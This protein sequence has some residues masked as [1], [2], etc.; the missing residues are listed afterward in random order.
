MKRK[1]NKMFEERYNKVMNEVARSVR[2][3]LERLDEDE[4]E[5]CFGDDC[6]EEC[7]D[8][9]EDEDSLN[10]MGRRPVRSTI[11]PKYKANVR[12]ALGRRNYDEQWAASVKPLAKFGQDELLQRY[13]VGLLLLG[14]EC[15]QT[16]E[17]IDD[18]AVFGE[19]ARK[20]LAQG[21][22]LQEIIDLYNEQDKITIQKRQGSNRP[23]KAYRKPSD[24]PSTTFDFDNTEDGEEMIDEVEPV[25][26][27]EEEQE[28][29][30]NVD[31][32]PEITDEPEE[33]FPAY[34]DVDVED[35][36]EVDLNMEDDEEDEM[37]DIMDDEEVEDE[38]DEHNSY[39]VI[40]NLDELSEEDYRD[41]NY[42]EAFTEFG[43]NGDE[44]IVE[45]GK[46]GTEVK[47]VADKDS[48]V[49]TIW[50]NSAGELFNMIYAIIYASFD[51]DNIFIETKLRPAVEA[52][53]KMYMVKISDAT[54]DANE[55]LKDKVFL[56]CFDGIRNVSELVANLAKFK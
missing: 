43:A 46:I 45:N 42:N 5:E 48:E 12:D 8:M 30:V 18:I 53:Y 23:V 2:A 20:F 28:E 19:Y 31:E 55:E 51:L 16:E 22:T 25:V 41:S 26:N 21:G 10:E 7:G 54:D 3:I 14:K 38:D 39:E 37:I 29:E 44:F 33:E 27:V 4:L 13:V 56:K 36:A 50:A 32:Y 17:D 47:F 34:D 1:A 15:P 40:N 35:A 6:I 24:E 52:I 49:Y 9:F 11:N